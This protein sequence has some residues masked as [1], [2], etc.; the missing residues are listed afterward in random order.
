M[1][2]NPPVNAGDT[3]SMPGS[4]RYPG[5]ENDYSLQYSC[6]EN[7]IDGGAWRAIVHAVAKSLISLNG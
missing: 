2:K 1:V 3:G 7:S 4:G 5:K 6:P